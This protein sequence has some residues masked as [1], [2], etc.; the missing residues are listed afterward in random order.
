MTTRTSRPRLKLPIVGRRLILRVPEHS[1][2]LVIAD[3]L[4][5]R[6][7]TRPIHLPAAY[8]IRDAR[9][10]IR[11]NT[12]GQDDGSKCNL[13]ITLRGNGE[14]IGG[15]GLDQIRLDVR[16]AHVGY[17]LARPYWGKGY[18]SEAASLLISA[19]FRELGLHRIHTGV[20]PDNPRS[21]RVLRRLGFRRE[22]RAREDRIVDGRYRDLILF[23]L[24]RREFRSYRPK[25]I[26]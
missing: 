15:C 11:R 22:G 26:S 23:G 12:R 14:L 24:I 8:S 19:A 17:W 2:A 10:F 9:E 16:N 13:F 7:V 20:F 4:R 5:D 21:M 1:D 18:A 25:P 6:R 3:A